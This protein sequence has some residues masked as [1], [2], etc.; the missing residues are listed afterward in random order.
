LGSCWSRQFAERKLQLKKRCEELL[1]LGRQEKDA[2]RSKPNAF[3]ER[4]FTLKYKKLV[5]DLEDEMTMLN[6]CYKRNEINPLVPWVQLFAGILSAVLTISWWIQLILEIFLQVRL[7][8][9]PTP[10][11]LFLLCPLPV[12]LLHYLSC[13]VERWAAPGGM[14]VSS[15]CAA[16]AARSLDASRE[17]RPPARAGPSGTLPLRHLHQA[18]ARLPALRHC[19]VRRMP[20]PPPTPTPHPRASALAS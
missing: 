19:G 9:L 18:V 7:A 2:F 8:A 16:S 3:K 5:L 1:S 11:V 14:S 6:V 13:V 10:H 12:S 15:A 20:P 17:H 4:R